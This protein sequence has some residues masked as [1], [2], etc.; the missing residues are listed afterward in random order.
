MSTL[1]MRHSCQPINGI[2]IGKKAKPSRVLSFADQQ[3][4]RQAIAKLYAAIE[5]TMPNAASCY[6]TIS[7]AD[8]VL[9]ALLKRKVG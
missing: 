3:E 5:Y 8:R 6:Y 1:T 2:R 7:D 4:L 9:R